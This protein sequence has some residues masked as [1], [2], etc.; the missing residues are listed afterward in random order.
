MIKYA[1][2]DVIF[3]PKIYYIMIEIIKGLK[4]LNI[5]DIFK[6][7]DLYLKYPTIN[8]GITQNNRD[9]SDNSQIQGLLK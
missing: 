1:A 3:L 6:S 4:N 2:N 5:T 9:L 7:C 8:E